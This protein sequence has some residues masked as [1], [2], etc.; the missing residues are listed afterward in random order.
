MRL[1]DAFPWRALHFFVDRR[2]RLPGPTR[3]A[4]RGRAGWHRSRCRSPLLWRVRRSFSAP[5]PLKLLREATE[6]VYCVGAELRDDGV[7]GVR[8]AFLRGPA[9]SLPVGRPPKRA[10]SGSYARRNLQTNEA[11]SSLAPDGVGKELLP[12][13]AE[14]PCAKR[15]IGRRASWSGDAERGV[16]FPKDP[17]SWPELRWDDNP[18]GSTNMSAERF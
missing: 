3:L 9:R 13:F 6:C 18:D 2:G 10:A 17:R 14:R 5:S 1:E 12:L 16:V 8:A 11:R 4:W 15:R 7:L